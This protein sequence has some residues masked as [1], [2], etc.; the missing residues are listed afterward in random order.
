MGNQNENEKLGDINKKERVFFSN[1]SNELENNNISSNI[2]KINKQIDKE[3]ITI[4]KIFK[5]TL[6]EKEK[7]KFTYLELYLAQ[8]IST[9]KEPKFRMDNL[10]DIILNLLNLK[11]NILQY[12]F[13]IYH[14]SIEMIEK[15]FRNE[16]DSNYKKIHKYI[17][18]YICMLLTSPE[19]LGKIIPKEKIIEIITQYFNDCDMDELGY[20]LFD[21]YLSTFHDYDYLKKVFKYYF[22][23]LDDLN[24]KNCKNFYSNKECQIKNME[25][26]S[27]LFKTCPLVSKAFVEISISSNEENFALSFLGLN[28]NGIIFQKEN[29]IS[30][31]IDI[32]PIEGDIS[33]MKKYINLNRVIEIEKVIDNQIIKLNDY[34]NKV[35]DFFIIIYNSDY[36]H[37]IMKWV[38]KLI[39]VNL[40]KLKLYKEENK[41]STNGFLLNILMI[42]MNIF[43]RELKKGENDEKIYSEFIFKIVGMIDPLF[44]LSKDKIDFSKIERTNPKVVQLVINDENFKN[45]IPEKFSI[46]TELFF[47]I[48]MIITYTIKSFSNQVDELNKNIEEELSKHNNNI[49]GSQELQNMLILEKILL[50]YLKNKQL[51]KYL[52][53]F[54]EVTTFFIFSLNNKKYSQNEFS[55]NYKNINY[56]EFLDD[57]YYFVNFN[58]NFTISLLPQNI[59]NNII[60]VSLFIRNF[61]GDSLIQYLY[62]TKAI[63]YFSLIFSCNI[64]LIQNPHFRMEI[65]DIMIYFFLI[66][67]NEKRNKINQIFKLLNEKYI[68]ESLMVSILRVFIDA[69]RLGTSN[70]FY[71]KFTVR[72]KI[73]FLIDNINKGY[74]QLFEDNIKT[75]SQKNNEEST[76]MINLL[77]NDI[78]YLNDECIENLSIIKKYQD[79]ISNNEKYSKLS[80]ENK[81]FEESK[82]KE[83]DRI[84]KA[85]IKLFNSSLK[86]LISITNILQENFIKSGLIERLVNLLNYSLNIFV[87]SRGND[88][89]V[90]NLNEYE[91]NPKFILA[92]ILKV[93]SSFNDYK[94]FLEF[95][96]KDEAY[97]K[98]DNFIKAKKIV[99]ETEKIPIDRIS[100]EKFNNLIN[101]LKSVEEEI[102]SK[103][104]NFDDAPSEFLDPITTLIM[105]DPVELPISKVIVDRKTI[106][107]HLLSD[108]NDPFSKTKLTKEMLIPCNELKKRIN[109]Y[110][111]KKKNEK[112]EKKENEK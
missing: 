100:F 58:D 85:E 26:L 16:Y 57:F 59:Y 2:N 52:L 89:H 12:L 94:E 53:R 78:T 14:R 105:Y 23:Y 79:L 13:E 19:N 96:V 41:L 104:I 101:K 28:E 38:Y 67:S 29:Y 8:L 73:L 15:R 7:D 77:M 91:F 83:K 32:S 3:H 35:T 76:K 90:K 80:E 6:D 87:T 75:Y 48:Q 102:K 109:E 33:D 43:F 68:K 47:I 42:L 50:I 66:H 61:N 17:T 81:K 5:I 49:K 18:N 36:E 111:Q 45:D 64:N 40:D 30:K 103:E 95:I 31:Y 93:Y 25:I 99:E 74:G 20:I 71:E 10:D 106:E 108:Q 72:Q 65:F 98:Y 34:L 37:N 97:Y 70:Q 86:F 9:D 4:S 69:E 39:S 112:M 63:I 88:I 22:N 84:V 56:K 27:A 92:S 82:F 60:T 55:K 21:F 11:E 24:K 110:I 46:Y 107:Q 54:S 51:Y 44:T 62:C 1:Y